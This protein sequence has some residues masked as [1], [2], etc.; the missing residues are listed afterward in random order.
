[1]SRFERGAIVVVPLVAVVTLAAGLRIGASPAIRAAVVYGAPPS[2]DRLGLA[3]QLVTLVDDRGVREAIELPEVSV[4]ARAGDKEARWRGATNSD[5]VA[6]VWLGLPDIQA[7]DPL[8]MQVFASGDKTPLAAGVVSWPSEVSR[9][10]D[11]G[12]VFAR[13]SKQSGE[14]LLE[15]AAYGG[16]LVPGFPSSI[17][18]RVRSRVSGLGV[19]GATVEAEAEPGLSLRATRVTTDEAG[20]AEFS[21]VAEIHVVALGLR[22]ASKS[23]AESLHGEWFGAL[24]VAPGASFVAMPLSVTP[25]EPA[26]LDVVVP[27]VVPRVYAEIDDADGR[28]FAASLAVERRGSENGGHA[29]LELRGLS[30]GTY[31][32]VT[33]GAPRA[34]E[35]VEGSAVARPFVVEKP[36]TPGTPG[37]AP[38]RELGPRL[39]TLATPRFARFV[40]LDGLPGKRQADGGRHRRGLALAFGSLLIAA[41]LETLL[42]LRGVERSRRDLAR[43]AEMLDEK[44]ARALERRFSVASVV[45]GLLLAL[46]GF[47]LLAALLTWKAS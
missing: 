34:A 14:L 29:S 27:T 1:M 10:P 30:A 38:L 4:V 39:A 31:W 40:A 13:P 7:G 41:A 23:G 45:I 33:S 36:G 5:G 44:E 42:V 18:V 3:W 43:V 6:E 32:L 24:P 11:L 16:R 21:A 37:T 19:A 15:V 47:A 12:A 8:S 17:W 2:A 9:A 25:G 22:A 28:A 20:W 46:L 26:K 35:N